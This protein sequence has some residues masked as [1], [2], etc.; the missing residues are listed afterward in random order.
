MKPPALDVL[1]SGADVILGR[2]LSEAETDK[3]AKYLNLLSK[4]NR[5]QRLVGSADPQWIIKRLFLD[6]L[7][8]LRVLPPEAR[9]VLDLGSGAGLPGIPLKIVRDDACVTLLEARRKRASFLSTV[10]RELGLRDIRVVNAR[11]DEVAEDLAGQFD[12]VVMRCAGKFG[13][14]AAPAAKLL[15]P[16]GLIVASGPPSTGPLAL[17]EW[18]NVRIDEYGAPRRFAVYR[19]PSP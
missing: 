4:W 2:P 16:G 11:L 17:G 6:S 8:F 12:A 15:G 13:D 9:Q 19:L 14:L 5:S 3:F 10:V 1:T 18:V 7:L